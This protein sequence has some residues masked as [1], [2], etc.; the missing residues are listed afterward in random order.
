MSQNALGTL[1]DDRNLM[2]KHVEANIH[3]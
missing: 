3:N 2:P 1:P